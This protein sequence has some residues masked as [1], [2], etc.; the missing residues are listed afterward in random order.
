MN[1]HCIYIIVSHLLELVSFLLLVLAPLVNVVAT[2]SRTIFRVLNL[3]LVTYALCRP[4]TVHIATQITVTILISTRSWKI[5]IRIQQLCCLHRKISEEWKGRKT[6]FSIS[7]IC[8]WNGS[9]INLPNSGYFSFNT[10]K[11]NEAGP[12]YESKQ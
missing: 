11:M 12:L 1:E 10:P 6:I 3:C 9:I 5:T 2:T 7:V 4:P 8:L